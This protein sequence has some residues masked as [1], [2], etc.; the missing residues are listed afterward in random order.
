MRLEGIST[1]TLERDLQIARDIQRGFLPEA[2]PKL[3][4]WEIAAY[5]E[6]ARLVGG[7]FYDA[8]LLTNNRRLGVVIADV[9]DKGVGAALFM[10]L[11]RT[12]IRAF[13]MQHYALSWADALT[14]E[15]TSKGKRALPSIGTGALQN[16]ITLTNNYIV[17]HHGSSGMFATVFFGIIDPTNG[18]LIYVNG[19][20]NPPIIT[21]GVTIKE[22]L[23]PSG[24]ALGFLPNTQ[25]EIRQ[26]QLEPGDTLL[27][28]TDGVTEARNLEKAFYTEARL[29]TLVTT[30][31]L[32]AQATLAR[33]EQ[34][35]KAFTGAAEQSDDITL[36][37]VSHSP[38]PK[39]P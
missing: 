35:L 28:Y 22:T 1:T 18:S 7:D 39:R 24:P 16:A 27:L 8:F 25:W 26:A 11:F 33:I 4:G 14:G 12:L 38:E 21:D 23:K 6:P 19:G 13:A 17:E 30:K 10:A 34:D 31:P 32:S 5:F 3:E 37:A 20:H 15:N 29:Q 9:C 36:L 2:L